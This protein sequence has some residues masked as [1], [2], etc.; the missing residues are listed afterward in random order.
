M[1]TLPDDL[2]SLIRLAVADLERCEVSEDYVVDMKFWHVPGGAGTCFV[3]LAG[4]VMAQTLGVDAQVD[5]TPGWSEERCKLWALDA[6]RSGE[7]RRA[8]KLM[9]KDPSVADRVDVVIPSYK[10]DPE[11]FKREMLRLAEVLDG[12][13]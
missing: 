7:L 12:D 10:A 9:N 1:S 13:E 4:A 6:V 5:A 11:G 8:L 3:C 2:P